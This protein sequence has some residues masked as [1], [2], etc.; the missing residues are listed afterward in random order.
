MEDALQRLMKES[1]STKFASVA[2]AAHKALGEYSEWN[3]T[4]L[5]NQHK[6]AKW[7]SKFIKWVISCENSRPTARSQEAGL[8][9]PSVNLLADLCK[10]Q[11]DTSARGPWLG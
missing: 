9:Q 1:G 10:L 3:S 5:A 6:F 11:D 8:T 4:F 7:Y 2:T